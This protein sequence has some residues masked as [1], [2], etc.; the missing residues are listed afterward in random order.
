MFVQSEKFLEAH[1]GKRGDISVYGQE[2]NPTTVRLAQMNLAI[3]GIEAKIA[4]GDTFQNDQHKDL[5]ADYIIANP[6]FNI[7][8]YNQELLKEDYRWKYGVPPSGNANYAWLQHFISK[9][10]TT[11]T[12]GIVL[13][14]GSMTSNTGGEGEIRKNLIEAKLVDCMVSLPGQLFFNTQIPACLW[15][16]ARDRKNNKFRNREKEILFIDARNLG[17]MISRKN[18]DLSEEDIKKISDTYHQWRNKGGN[19]EDIPGFCKSATIDEVAKNG[20]VLTPGRY[21]GNEDVEEDSELFDDK[22]A[23]LTSN[24]KEQ[25][26]KSLEL[27]EE[28]KK[29]LKK[30]GFEI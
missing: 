20:Y 13:A 23:G 17:E 26:E 21:V 9:L 7:S 18:K 24:L 22:M 8:D 15:F 12:A 19:Y 30:I 16:L 3:R 5:K 2:S 1:G 11:G 4:L 28:I 14:N 27:Q 29:N 25:F 6:P 10:N